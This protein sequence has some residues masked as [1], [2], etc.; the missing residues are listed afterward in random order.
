MPEPRRLKCCFE[1]KNTVSEP[2]V[3]SIRPGVENSSNGHPW[4]HT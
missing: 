4:F 3:L 1:G 2:L